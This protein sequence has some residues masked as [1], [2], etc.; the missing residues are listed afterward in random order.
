MAD[1]WTIRLLGQYLL[2]VMSGTVE[3]VKNVFNSTEVMTV[4]VFIHSTIE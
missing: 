3:T 4:K 2:R 1:G